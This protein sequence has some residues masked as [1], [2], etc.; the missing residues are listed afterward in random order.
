MG[1]RSFATLV[2]MDSGALSIDRTLLSGT[3]GSRI[4]AILTVRPEGAGPVG[5]R[6][7]SRAPEPL[8]ELATLPPPE[9]PGAVLVDLRLPEMPFEGELL[10]DVEGRPSLA[11]PVSARSGAPARFPAAALAARA[12]ELLLERA[13][14]ADGLRYFIE[15][16]RRGLPLELLVREMA[17]AAAALGLSPRPSGDLRRL[18]AEEMRSA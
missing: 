15:A 10:I 16:L 1:F 13:P 8:R 11:V 5:L 14:D 4:A 17:R 12:Y 2:S 3:C 9:E 18:L 7:R 6:L